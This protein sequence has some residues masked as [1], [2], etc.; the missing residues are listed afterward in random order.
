MVATK[1]IDP[2]DENNI[3]Y[4]EHQVISACDATEAVAKYTEKND[5]NYFDGCIIRE[6]N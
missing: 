4:G 3:T 2:F 5:C 6:I 1:F